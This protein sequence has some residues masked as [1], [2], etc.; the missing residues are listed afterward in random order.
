MLGVAII[1]CGQISD[2][3]VAAYAGRDDA[4]I[5]ALV[6]TD[7]GAAERTSDRWQLQNPAI[8]TDY[9]SVLQRPE[10]DLVE[11]LV[12][13]HLHEEVTV[14]A[15]AAGKHVSL[16]KPMAVSR[17]E[18][19][20]LVEAG[21]RAEGTLRVFENFIFYPPVQRAKAV[22]DSGVLGD[23]QSIRIK[24][25]VGF[26]E[27]AWPDP[28][29]PW[30]YDSRKCG[31]GPMVFDDGHHKFALAWYLVGP[32]RAV[33]SWVK[34]TEI[35]PGR[36]LDAPAVVSWE[37]ES[38][39]LGCLEVTYSPGLYVETKQ[40]PQDD[41]IEVTGTRG[42]MWITRGHG[43]L[44][45]IAPLIVRRGRQTDYHDDMD[46]DWATSFR[47]STE[48][49]LRS[50]HDGTKP[51]LTASEGREI[52]SFALAAQESA[53]SNRAIALDASSVVTENSGQ[54]DYRRESG[55]EPA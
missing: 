30:R 39:A 6:D 32:A 25:G 44:L 11:V 31:G 48:H 49:F 10:V 50:L 51:L 29:E 37:H 12:P 55:P 16:Q 43:R 7:E 15:L 23:I 46:I 3:H 47:L 9:H 5:V 17:T 38:G 19:D 22:I 27:N 36:W 24:S 4:R 21:E 8:A 54:A 2:L 35:E 40:Y 34:W 53:R 42:V 18:A 41:R 26:C 20:T 14:A 28:A 45:D 33:H 1:G 52:L 13:H